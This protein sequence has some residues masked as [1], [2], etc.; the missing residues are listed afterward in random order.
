[1]SNKQYNNNGLVIIQSVN[2]FDKAK[3]E[4]PTLIKRDKKNNIFFS[5][6]NKEKDIKKKSNGLKKILINNNKMKIL[7]NT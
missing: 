4:N 2:K 7:W 1:M 3:K 5:K 6:P